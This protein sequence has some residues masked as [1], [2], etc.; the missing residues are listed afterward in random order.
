[1]PKKLFKKNK[2]VNKPKQL[3][4]F[5]IIDPKK[6]LSAATLTGSLLLT[7]AAQKLK[8]LPGKP[9]E[10]RIP[11]G[12]VSSKEL[13]LLLA[14]L[15]KKVLPES[16]RVLTNKEE[17]L[18]SQI[19]KKTLGIEASVELDDN[20]LNH[21][22][23]MMGLE[24]HLMRYPDDK[25]LAGR[26]FPAAGIAPGKAAWGYWANNRTQLTNADYQMERYYVAVQTLYLPDWKTRLRELRD[27]YK[28]RKVL[29]INP[30]NGS[31]VV[32]VIGDAGPAKW[33]GKQFGGSPEVIYELGFYPTKHKGR[34][35]IFFIDDKDNK[36]PLGPI[37]Y[38]THVPKP[39]TA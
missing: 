21:Q 35:I 14:D 36:I 39:K 4:K 34:T 33:T 27:W 29:I 10:L 7:P 19:I 8:A 32:A 9:P 1:M 3:K 5:K 15:L 12:L 28:Y 6:I 18:M 16:S 38:P 26:N 17:E 20:R 25:S 2:A 11:H 23:G 13:K 24:Q 22:I 30:A 37:K 31:A